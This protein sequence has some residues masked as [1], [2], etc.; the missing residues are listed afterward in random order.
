MVTPEEL[1]AFA[2]RLAKDPSEV[3]QRAAVS[4]AYYAAF[5]HVAGRLEQEGLYR[6]RGSAAHH[7][8]VEEAAP[9]LA[10]PAGHFL[11]IL[12]RKRNEADY[13]ID[14]DFPAGSMEFI[15]LSARRLLEL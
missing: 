14:D 8:R 15:L 12:R 2:E 4:R 13:D 3:S 10:E 7:G 5:L 6:R 1:I 11:Y 9:L